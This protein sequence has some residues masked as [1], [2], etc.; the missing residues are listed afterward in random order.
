MNKSFCVLGE[1]KGKAR[2]RVTRFGTYTPEA[3]IM[4][5]NLVKTEYRRQCA[6]YRF[7]DNQ[8]L[9]LKVTAEFGIPS[10]TSKTKRAHMM[11][12]SIRPIKRPDWDNIGKI[13]SDALNKVAYRDDSQVVECLVSKHYSDH[14]K[15]SVTIS[16]LS[17]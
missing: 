15:V 8:P 12:G 2:A 6:D 14:P 4:Y 13:V 7:S 16:A 5:E 3:T 10:G 11:N 1:P 9:S 17:E